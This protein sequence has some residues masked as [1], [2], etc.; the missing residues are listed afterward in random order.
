MKIKRSNLNIS[1]DVLMFLVMMPVVGI[2]F[3]IKYVLLNG[4][5]RNLVYGND[6]DLL[7]WGMD[8]HQWGSIHLYL[9]LVLIVLLVLHII[10]H[11]KMMIAMFKG[12]VKAPVWRVITA[13]ALVLSVVFLAIAPLF[14]QP[15]VRASVTHHG[16]SPQQQHL[17]RH[18]PI[19]AEEPSVLPNEEHHESS[20]E[21]NG[22]MTLNELSERYDVSAPV[23][24]QAIGVP[25]DKA[26]VTLGRL[27]KQ[28]AFDMDDLRIFIEEKVKKKH[29]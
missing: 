12:M 8:R 9:G 28:Y 5:E 10:F 25:N 1:I 6:V 27:K 7:F 29:D 2:G 4:V 3:L 11:W 18:E 21:I 13:V 24:C 20:I 19:Q 16:H 22:R 26:N 17:E 15:E 23:L 14:V